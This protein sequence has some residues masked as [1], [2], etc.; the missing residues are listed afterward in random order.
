[1]STRRFLGAFLLVAL[2]IAGVASYYASSQPDGLT[3]VS[4]KAGF[5][6]QA[7]KSRTSDSPL[8]GYSTKGID[9]DRISGG[10]AGVVGC[11]LVLGLAGGLFWVVR[12]RGERTDDEDAQ[13]HAGSEA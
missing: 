9:D 12:S 13:A 7:K 5:S 10:L 3:S 8:A 11:L 2:V 1:M 6:D 4:E